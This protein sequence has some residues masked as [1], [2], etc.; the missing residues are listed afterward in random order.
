VPETKTTIDRRQREGIYELIRNHLGSVGDLWNALEQAEDFAK[1][2]QLGREFAEDFRLLADVGWAES[3][4][5]RRFELTMPPH[6]LTELLRRLRDE[7][8][9]LLAESDDS[10]DDAETNERLHCGHAA[11]EELL[12]RIESPAAEDEEENLPLAPI[13][14]V[15]AERTR[16]H[17][18]TAYAP[19][20]D[21]F[22]LAALERAELHEQGEAVLTDVLTEHLGFE[23]VPS[24]NRHLWP[25]YEKLRCAG[26]LTMTEPRGEPLWSLTA[27][28]RERLAGERD[29]GE[30][31]E[32][33]EAPQHRAWRHARV[34]AAVRIEGFK[35]EL[36]QAVEAAET[37][38]NQY[39][40]V[41]SAQWLELS[42]RLRFASWRFASAT[43]CLTEWP[44]PE[45]ADPDPDEHPGPRPGRR[46]IEAWNQDTESKERS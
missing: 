38:I 9:A 28:G 35:E 16:S 44:E 13:S 46:A 32:L 14:G 4:R 37:L 15:S 23:A 26:L 41:M 19:V 2:E 21:G 25:R 3:E 22:I 39:R 5:R 30:I 1:A 24:N 27:V 20:T 10:P 34:E 18:L 45:D 29:A 33:P 11:C 7:A 40:P 17:E 43:Y 42:E 36:T 6:D 31:G 12:A 8:A